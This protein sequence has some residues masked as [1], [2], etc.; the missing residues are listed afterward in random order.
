[1]ADETEGSLYDNIL[2][3]TDN[4]KDIVF[5]RYGTVTE[6]LNGKCS[7]KELDSDLI[8]SNVPVTGTIPVSVGN[9]VLLGFVDNDLYQP[10]IIL[11]KDAK[12]TAT[13][14]TILALGIGLFK[15]KDDGHLYVEL[16]MGM[17]NIF[18]IDENGHLLVTLPESATN[19][20]RL[21]TTDGH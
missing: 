14:N 6:V 11:N 5:S 21:N 19:S 20:Y 17:E 16:P 8:H 1:M 10:Y 4:L 18:E 9:V 13:M 3:A 12:D 7:V 15:I 2:Q